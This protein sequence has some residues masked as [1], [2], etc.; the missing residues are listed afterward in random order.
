MGSMAQIRLKF[1]V[2]MLIYLELNLDK[3]IPSGVHLL[4]T[5]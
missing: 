5:G 3:R 1:S 4:A 2:S